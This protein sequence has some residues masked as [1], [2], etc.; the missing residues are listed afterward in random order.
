MLLRL[1]P[2]FVRA[3]MDECDITSIL[4]LRRTS[5]ALHHH[6]TAIFMVDRRKLLLRYTNNPD[7]LWGHLDET[8]AVVG[9]F[10]ALRFML[11]IPHVHSDP[12]D[13]YVSRMEGARLVQILEED[14]TLDYD[15]QAVRDHKD[16]AVI[17]DRGVARTTT[18]A[19]PSGGVIN[20]HTSLSIS[21]VDPIAMTGISALINWVSPFAFACGYP[22]L[23]LR[24]LSLGGAP[25]QADVRVY[26]LYHQLY[27]MGFQIASEPSAWPEYAA[28]VTTQPIYFHHTCLR[29]H[30]VCP[31]QGR[32]FGDVGSMVTVFDL[33]HTDHQELKRNHRHPVSL[34]LGEQPPS[35][36]VSWS[37]HVL[38]SVGVGPDAN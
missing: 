31:G 37:A 7:R 25:Q 14:E 4:S 3:I 16:D 33:I 10:A 22:M 23:T 38:A 27:L 17:L 2:E 13:I 36:D 24:R 21:S 18:F 15:V 32:F 8:R 6:A 11:R 35:V 34:T 26:T 20:V 1:A 29:H 30:Y 9:G 12:L 28:F 19:S 5:A